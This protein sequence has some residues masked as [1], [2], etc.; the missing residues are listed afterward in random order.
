MF[1]RF[2]SLIHDGAIGNIG[3]WTSFGGGNKFITGFEFGFVV[4]HPGENV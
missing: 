3:R 4:G 1:L 2:L